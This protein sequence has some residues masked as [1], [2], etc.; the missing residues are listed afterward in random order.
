MRKIDVDASRQRERDDQRRTRQK[1]RA[2]RRMN[3]RLEIAVARQHGA[4]HD[5]VVVDGFLKTGIDRTG[6]AEAGRAT[7]T[8][9]H[10][11]EFVEIALQT[12][13][14]EI[15]ADHAR[16]G[17]QR[18]LD[19]RLGLQSALDGFLREHA[20]RQHHARVRRVG[21][22]RDRGDH[23]VAV[24]RRTFRR[25][26]A[27]SGFALGSAGSRLRPLYRTRRPPSASS[28]ALANCGLRSAS[29]MRSCGRLGPATFGTIAARSSVN[30]S[31]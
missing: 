28:T 25:F 3:A 2:H 11:A 13:R 31:E 23:H 30:T 1:R 10:E 9:E 18:H 29:A 4:R 7:V 19:P 20:G 21:A 27:P 5:V 6:R 14:R 26:R 22:R 15:F 12:R 8:R 24:A 17:C 16:A